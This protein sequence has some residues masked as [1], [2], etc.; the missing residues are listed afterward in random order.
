MQG[1]AEVSLRGDSSA[2]RL[3]VWADQTDFPVLDRCQIAIWAAAGTTA[4]S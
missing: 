2:N 3:T 1:I 4:S